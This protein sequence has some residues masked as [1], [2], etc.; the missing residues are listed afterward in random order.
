MLALYAVTVG[1]RAHHVIVLGSLLVAGLLPI[2][3]GAD[4]SNVGPVLA[5]ASAMAT[6][7]STTGS[8]SEPSGRRRAW[9]FAT[10]MPERSDELTALDR[11]IHEP[12]RLAILTVLSLRERGRLRVPA[13]H[14][15]G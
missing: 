3:G 7:I 9:A 8:S 4:P 14:D 2:W 12:G 15:P 10:A 6:G 11:L 1:L 5:G 13:A